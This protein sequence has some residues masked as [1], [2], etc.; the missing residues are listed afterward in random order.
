MSAPGL[1]LPN[2]ESIV[3]SAGRSR[4]I[5][6]PAGGWVGLGMVAFFMLMAAV[7][8]T[9]VPYS[10]HQTFPTWQ[11]PGPAHWLGTD[12]YGQDILTQLV[13]GSRSSIVVGT[14]AGLLA[15][16]VGVTVGLTAGYLG[17]AVGEVLMRIVDVLLVI[18]TL[19][20]LIL[21]AAFLP[22]AGVVTQI[23]VIGFLSWLWM[24][25]SIR[26]QTLSERSRGYV[27]VARVVGLS[28]GEI[29]FR[30]IMP[31]VLP[32][33]ISNLVLVI[34]ASILAQASLSF[35]GIGDAT[36]VSWGQMLSLAYTDNAVSRNAWW[37]LVP[38]GFSIA[39]LA[40]GFVL[41]G[42]AVL[43]VYTASGRED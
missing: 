36:T 33:A 2:E 7:G 25:R 17:G 12:N 29:M 8:P 27:D 23:L 35:L 1:V 41:V 6:L 15:S 13:Y 5:S 37:W 42:N 19:A 39:F 43:D 16:T 26:S 20:L 14:L 40:Y 4:W 21:I 22:S 34:T 9:L 24:A 31:N 3:E 18:P 11:P 28:D 30:E 10:L 38:P 32:I